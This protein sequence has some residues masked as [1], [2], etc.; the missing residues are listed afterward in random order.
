MFPY[1]EDLNETTMMYG[2]FTL[3]VSYRIKKNGEDTFVTTNIYLELVQTKNN[4]NTKIKAIVMPK[5]YKINF[6]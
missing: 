1:D 5:W 6:H 3:A 4:D 2:R